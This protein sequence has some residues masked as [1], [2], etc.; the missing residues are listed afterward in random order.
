MHAAPD[1]LT[2]VEDRRATAL[3]VLPPSAPHD[4]NIGPKSPAVAA[5]SETTERRGS[6]QR[7]YRNAL[8][9]AAADV[10]NIDAARQNAR[11]ERSWQSILTDADLRENLTRAQASDAETQAL[12]SRDALLQSVRSAW[13]HVLHPAPP[14]REDS[15][16]NIGPGYVMHSTRLINRGGA[17]S[18]PQAV[19]DKVSTD[20]T[21]IAEMGPQNLARSLEPVW[22]AD[23]PH[24]SIEKIRDWF[25]SYVYMP[26]LRDDATLDGV[27]QRLVKDL[28]EPY[29]Y[30]SSFDEVAGTYDGAIEGIVR[31]AD[32]RDGGLLVRRGAAKPPP[33]PP[34]PPP[35]PPPP[36]L[37]RRFFASIQIEPERA[38]LE[39]ARIMD[40]LLVELTRSRGSSLRVTLE[41][42][43]SAGE[44]GYP[45]DV[46]D[47]VQANAR[48]LNVDEKKFG[49]ERD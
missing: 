43:G 6:G 29:V 25:A 32:D 21:V 39:V 1:N 22:P 31:L 41:I 36:N 12:R 26:R 28:A 18:I 47:T 3:I 42:H 49:F 20:G 44:P 17:K 16:S 8:V 45:K 15:A 34:P 13:V 14:E 27:L 24:T 2:D 40:A 7:R 10:T 11:R 38:G 4:P 35:P 19:W 23:Q 33:V 5:A 48:D 46:V 30:A 9:F 37:Q